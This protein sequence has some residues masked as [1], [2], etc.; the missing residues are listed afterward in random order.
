M[1]SLLES[2]NSSVNEAVNEPV[3]EAKEG[4]NVYLA[5]NGAM[6]NRDM[7]KI[8]RNFVYDNDVQHIYTFDTKEVKEISDLKNWEGKCDGPH[9]KSLDHVY[10]H[11]NNGYNFV[12]FMQ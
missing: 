4:I 10:K 1:K 12:I 11:A 5:T 2:I 9:P 6:N 7:I 3:N 8:V